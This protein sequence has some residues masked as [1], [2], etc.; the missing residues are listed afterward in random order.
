MFQ[1][2]KSSNKT[3][4]LKTNSKQSLICLKNGDNFFL[5]AAISALGHGNTSWKV[6]GIGN[7]LLCIS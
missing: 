3:L 5:L 2:P 7:V 1:N 4:H 6:T